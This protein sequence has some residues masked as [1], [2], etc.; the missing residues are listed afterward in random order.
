MRKERAAGGWTKQRLHISLI[1]D[2]HVLCIRS[3]HSLRSQLAKLSAIHA[4]LNSLNKLTQSERVIGLREKDS[5]SKQLFI[6]STSRKVS[7][8]GQK[9]ETSCVTDFVLIH[10]ENYKH[11]E[12][13]RILATP[14]FEYETNLC[15][16]LK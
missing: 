6:C 5:I 9:K 1:R 4:V 2:G 8:T 16:K 10:L 14:S 11:K 3:L 15:L 7:G 13:F 12:K